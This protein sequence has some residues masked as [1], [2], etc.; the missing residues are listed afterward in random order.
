FRIGNIM[1]VQMTLVVVQGKKN[2]FRMKPIL[3]VIVLLNSKYM[4]V[5][6]EILSNRSN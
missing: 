5:R 4:Q 3:R 1:E 6:A 2:V